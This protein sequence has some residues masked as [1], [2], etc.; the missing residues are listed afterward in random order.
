MDVM[1]YFFAAALGSW[2]VIDA[3]QVQLRLLCSAS[4]SAAAIC[5]AVQWNE[6]ALLLAGLAML[7]LLLALRFS[8]S[9]TA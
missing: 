4:W 6:A 7:W 3:R 9:R 5:V 8:R 2:F 1:L